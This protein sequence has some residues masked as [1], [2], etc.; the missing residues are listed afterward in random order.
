MF[1]LLAAVVWAAGYS[2][3]TKPGL[4]LNSCSLLLGEHCS[5]YS[6]W[7]ATIQVSVLRSSISYSPTTHRLPGEMD[8]PCVVSLLKE[9]EVKTNI[10]SIQ[11]SS[12]R[13][14][15]LSLMVQNPKALSSLLVF[16]G[17]ACCVLS[18]S[19]LWGCE[20]SCGFQLTVRRAELLTLSS[21]SL[22]LPPQLRS[23]PPPPPFSFQLQRLQWQPS[24]GLTE[25]VMNMWRYEQV[26]TICMLYTVYA[27]TAQCQG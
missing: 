20:L 24:C 22:S 25:E 15:S 4:Y 3:Q 12:G 26:S 11:T 14:L 1:I 7:P 6:Q 21:L 23:P 10:F 18:A 8:R 2:G 5:Y 19:P 9:N 17:R 27:L 13:I 16:P